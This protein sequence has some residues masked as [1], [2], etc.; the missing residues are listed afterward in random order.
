MKYRKRMSKRRSK[1]SFRK[2][3]KS[4]RHNYDSGFVKRGGMRF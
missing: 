1:R 4:R 3:L 2:G